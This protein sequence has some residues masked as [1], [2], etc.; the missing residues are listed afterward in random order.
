MSEFAPADAKT[1]RTEGGYA[2][3]R[4]DAG[5]ETYAGIA[6]H[7]WPHWPGWKLI[8]AAKSRADFP[9]CL[10]DNAELQQLVT[11]FYQTNFWSANR[12]GEINDQPL[13]D[14]TYDHIVNAGARGTMWLQLAA[15]CT[16]DGDI[17]PK[18][19]AAVNAAD[20]GAI[21]SRCEDIAGAYRLDRAAKDPSQI[22]FLTSWLTRDGQPPEIIAIVRQAAADGHLDAK[23]V[24][25]LKAA[26]AAV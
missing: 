26:M 19:I 6:R 25:D 14:W 10:K 23:E 18:T 22:Q 2:N 24:A 15:G 21:L 5:G 16:P 3:N 4:A 17:G 7:F 1:R 11:A 13:A 20:P 8:D 9:G 12:L